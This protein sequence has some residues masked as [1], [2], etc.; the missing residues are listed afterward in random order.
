MY[1]DFLVYV[2]MELLRFPTGGDGGGG[3]SDPPTQHHRGGL[4]PG[5]PC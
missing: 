2:S 4:S 1:I 5:P 3:G